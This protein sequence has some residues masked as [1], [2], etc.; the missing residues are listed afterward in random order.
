MTVPEIADGDLQFSTDRSRLD[1]AAIHRFI[2]DESYWTPGIARGLVERA[3]ANSLC[4]GVY[5]GA[6]QIGFAR[7][8][9]DY[10]GFA[11][12]AD[13]FVI[14]EWR[15]RGVA[16]RLMDFVFA[17]PQLQNMRRFLLATRDAHAL[18]ARCGFTPL[19]AP[20]H[21]MERF[22]ANALSRPRAVDGTLA[23]PTK[24]VAPTT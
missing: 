9:T 17:H 3:I 20:Q 2:S 4:F 23:A 7:V 19:S 5:A 24:S 16:K 22:D 11:Y 15:G 10:V 1:V 14:R 6:V 13:V 21:F 12:L 18:Y 8:V